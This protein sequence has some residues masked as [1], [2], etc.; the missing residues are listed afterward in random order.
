MA[1][2]RKSLGTI[3]LLSL[4]AAG[5]IGTSWIYTNGTYFQKYG[6][7]GM[8]FGLA[9]G[10][11]LATFIAMAYGELASKFPRAGGEVVYG[12]LGFN[13]GV[14]FV[15]GWLLIGAYLSSLAFYVTASGMLLSWVWPGMEQVRLYTIADTPVHLPVLLF[16]IAVTVVIFAINARGSEIG[17]RTQVVLFAAMIV[18]GLALV[19]VGFAAGSPHNFWPAYAP[20]APAAAD[21]ARFVIPAM[22]FLTGFSLVAILAEDAK[23]APRRL[24][25]TVGLTV[26]IAATFYCVVLLASAWVSPWQRTAAT[27]KGTIA[28]FTAAGFPALGWAAYGIAVLGLFTSFIALFTASARLMVAMSRAGLFPA[29]F[30]K[31][32]PRWGTPVNAL[33]F[34]MVLALALGWL[35][36][37]AVTWFLDTGGV[38]VGLAWFIGVA[39][40]YRIRRRYPD[41][42]GA[43]R[44]RPAWLPAI[45]GIAAVGVIVMVLVPGTPIALVWP[46]EYLILFAWVLLGTV[47]YLW[48]RRRGT[49]GGEVTALLGE[50]S[51]A[52]L[53]QDVRE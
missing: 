53:R 26:V 2:L 38:Y 37:G 41:V 23:M 4:G 7:G 31:L 46:A 15:G 29:A 47:I 11:V 39:S 8:I 32:H 21:T 42:R 19:V 12:Y 48:V 36:K 28:A 1:E 40:L 51:P 6:A 20:G 45:G 18:L 35:G 24:G 50:H 22:T 34:T 49:T 33:A 10:A 3:Q 9:I 44:V 43:Y 27:E 14:A 17:G 13:R 30:A 52:A 16:G 25:R 5:V